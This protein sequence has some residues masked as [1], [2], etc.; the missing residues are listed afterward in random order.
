MSKAKRLKNKVVKKEVVE[1]IK[2]DTSQSVH[3]GPKVDF[4]F[5]IRDFPFT[6]KQKAFID[7]AL[8]KNTNYIFCQAVAG[9]GKTLMSVY[10]GLKL[11]KE[12]RIKN[13]YFF[14]MPVESA[15]YGLGFIKGD[16]DE[17]MEAYIM[18]MMD[19]LHELLSP[20]DIKKLIDGGFIQS[21]PIGFLKGRTFNSSLVIVDEAEDLTAMDF[22]L[23]MSR[24]G[25]FS[26]MLLIGDTEQ[27]N[28]K[29]GVFMKVF[30]LFNS[31]ECKE[32]GIFAMSFGVADIMRNKILG[33]V[34]ERFN[35]L[36]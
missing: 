6:E 3:Q 25:K 29:H 1:E 2:K 32:K 10:I 5:N 30:D 15:S 22:R 36:K 13:I 23:V 24:L 26:K 33:F 9:V 8:E 35:F 18:P 16:L 7:I 11:L 34:I 28:V 21:L 20:S 31:E 19:Q 14:R 4:D 27:C 17:K 12:G